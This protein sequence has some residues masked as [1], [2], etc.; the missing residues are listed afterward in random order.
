MRRKGGRGTLLL[1]ARKVMGWRW[2][3]PG[4]TCLLLSKRYGG[5]RGG[6]GGGRRFGIATPAA[7]V[8]SGERTSLVQAGT[9]HQ[10]SSQVLRA[11]LC[12]VP[13]LT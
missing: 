1:W 11:I 8:S 5:K 9:H 6:G 12:R 3:L 13:R 10:L 4:A 7:C 2:Q